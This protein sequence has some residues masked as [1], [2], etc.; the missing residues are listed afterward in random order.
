[1]SRVYRETTL[2][3]AARVTE[4]LDEKMAL[5][6]KIAANLLMNSCQK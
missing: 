1:M 5:A 2:A 3:M 4:V 6:R